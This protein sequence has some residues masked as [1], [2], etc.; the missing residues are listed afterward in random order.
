M[1]NE[2]L[3]RLKHHLLGT[4]QTVDQ[5]LEKLEIG[6]D[7]AEAESSLLDGNPSVECC[8]DCGWWFESCDLTWSDEKNAGLCCDCCEPDEN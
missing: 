2:E 3:D 4:M 1:T 8:G 5:A 7:P 6:A